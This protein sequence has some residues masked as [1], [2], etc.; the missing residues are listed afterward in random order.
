[1][2]MDTGLCCMDHVTSQTMALTQSITVKR[3]SWSTQN[4][5]VRSLDHVFLNLFRTSDY[6]NP[7]VQKPSSIFLTLVTHLGKIFE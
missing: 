6:K 7:V 2:G 1:M 4:F 5:S 3:C